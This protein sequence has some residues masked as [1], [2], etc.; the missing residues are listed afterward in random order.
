MDI[1][2]LA[3]S[4]ESPV[5]KITA[6][7]PA[8]KNENRA[9]IFVNDEYAFSLDIAQIVDYR[10]KVGQDISQQK[11]IELQQ[12]SEFG[13]LYQSTL[14]WVLTK[15]RSIRETRDYLHRK[16]SR[17]QSENKLRTQNKERSKEDRARYHLKTKTLPLFSEQDI[18]QVID[19]LVQKKYLDDTK[20]TQVYIENRNAT[21]G[22]SLK[23][24]RQELIKKGISQELIEETLVASG[25]DDQSE[26]AKIIAKKKHKY[27]DRNKLKA[28]LVRQGFSY[29]DIEDILK[30]KDNPL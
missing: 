30:T 12:A 1:L 27:S 5:L 25:R 20:F 3:D 13:K 2:N 9:N 17:R 28:Y 18:D 21:K 10:L 11:F 8:A 7:K 26:L 14:E 19:R 4:S 29:S 6:I 23:K 24:L 16:L 22:T 15:P